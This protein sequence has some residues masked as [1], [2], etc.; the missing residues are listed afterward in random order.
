MDTKVCQTAPTSCLQLRFG[1]AWQRLILTLLVALCCHIAASAETLTVYNGTNNSNYLPVYGF[2]VDTQGTTSEFVIPKE[3]LGA[4]EDGTI[5]ALTF[6]LQTRA[7]AAWTATIQVY[8][9]EINA[10]TLTG[11]T[12]PE[13]STVV[14]TGTLDATG[15]VMTV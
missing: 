14:Y 1:G 4:M 9:K 11:I 3:Q 6:Y 12:G 10:T 7:A 5:S 15:T 13:A 8:L 2:G